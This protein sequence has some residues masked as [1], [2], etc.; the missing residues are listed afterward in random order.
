[1]PLTTISLLAAFGLASVHLF[2]QQLRLLQGVPRRHLLSTVGGM[3]VA[4]VILR[5]LPAISQHQET[6]QKATGN[7]FLGSLK[8]HAY[9]VV[10][11]SFIVFYGLDR[12][13]KRSRHNRK[14][15][16]KMD[17]ASHTV[18]WLHIATF[19]LMNVLIGYFLLHRADGPL[20]HLLLFFT[21]MLFKF[22]INDH[23]LHEDHKDLYD[24]TGRW[25]LAVAVLLGW[26][27]NYLVQVPAVGPAL[28]QAFIAG[29]VL[30][31]V[32]KEQL[33]EARQSR[34]RD[35]VLGALAYGAL[36]VAF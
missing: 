31:N 17:R 10:L 32:L 24:D 19:T 18:F 21:A 14:E 27:A 7:G 8:N 30:L 3:A 9:I 22:I 16:G 25:I 35:F 20:Q 29:G 34:Y 28:I 33:P 4:F 36:L 26:G 2:S 15:A 12:L 13:A 6:L 5:L 1:M 11:L 23:G